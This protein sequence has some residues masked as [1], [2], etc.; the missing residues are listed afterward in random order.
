MAR[1]LRVQYLG[2]IYHLMSRGDHQEAIFGH[3]LERQR[4]R[5]RI[6]ASLGPAPASAYS[7]QNACFCAT[8]AVLQTAAPLL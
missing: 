2:L 6:I 1:K 7:H 8:F 4:G 3:D 5:S